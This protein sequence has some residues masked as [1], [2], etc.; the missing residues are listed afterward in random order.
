MLLLLYLGFTI[1]VPEPKGVIPTTQGAVPFYTNL[2]NPQTCSGLKDGQS[3]NLTWW[4]NAT[5]N[6]GRIYNFFTIFDAIQ[7]VA[8]IGQDNT[9]NVEV[10]IG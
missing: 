2:T 4:V 10:M 8:Y 7:Y 6:S 5:G 1:A 9:T 3:C